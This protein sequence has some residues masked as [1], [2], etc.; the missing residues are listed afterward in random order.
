MR[1]C[2]LRPASDNKI[3]AGF[4]PDT[5]KN[6]P[7]ASRF[8]TVPDLASLTEL[9][10]ATGKTLSGQ[11]PVVIRITKDGKIIYLSSGYKIGIGEEIIRNVSMK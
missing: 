9:E 5:W 3:P 6:L 8:L 10:K 7:A 11:F 2:S 4:T 1:R